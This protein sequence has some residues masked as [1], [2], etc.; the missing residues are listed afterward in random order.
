M[1]AIDIRP[2]LPPG[3]WRDP[4]AYADLAACGPRG[5]A[6]ELLRR[7]PDYAAAMWD[8]SAAAG[9]TVGLAAVGAAFATRW[10]LHF[11]RGSE[12][13]RA[14]RAAPLDPRG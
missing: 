13:Q 3:S 11:R 6:W 12:G 7:H 2:A 1:A 14:C 4:A 8:L 9:D 5:L 10:G